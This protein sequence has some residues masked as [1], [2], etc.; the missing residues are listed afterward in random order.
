MYMTSSLLHQTNLRKA[1]QRIVPALSVML[2]CISFPF[3][4]EIG[5]AKLSAIFYFC[6]NS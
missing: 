1:L 4:R 5:D 3:G 6:S 2:S